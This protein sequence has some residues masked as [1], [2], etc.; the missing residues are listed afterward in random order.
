M[1]VDLRIG[2][3]AGRF[4]NP[5]GA[6]FYYDWD[7]GV[8]FYD[9]NEPV[10]EEPFQTGPRKAIWTEEADIHFKRCHDNVNP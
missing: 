10:K 6:G 2:A 3:N 5:D 8:Y 7:R 4:G 1:S 9:P